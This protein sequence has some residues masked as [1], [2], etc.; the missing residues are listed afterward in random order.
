[1]R[2]LAAGAE[3]FTAE[4]EKITVEEKC[5]LFHDRVISQTSKIIDISRRKSL[6]FGQFML[7]EEN[8]DELE[9][10]VRNEELSEKTVRQT[11]RRAMLVK[12]CKAII[13]TIFFT[14]WGKCLLAGSFVGLAA[15]AVGIIVT[16]VTTI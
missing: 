4:N 9:D 6:E 16:L 10:A 1:M 13:W 7:I 8:R 11:R 14:V 3:E 2:M 5:N 12:I 15:V